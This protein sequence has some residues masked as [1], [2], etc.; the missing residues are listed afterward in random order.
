MFSFSF[1]FVLSPTP[2]HDGEADPV[3]DGVE[4]FT[5]AEVLS[6]LLAQLGRG[7]IETGIDLC[8]PSS[9]IGVTDRTMFGEVI[10]GSS[11][12]ERGRAKGVLRFSGD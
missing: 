12:I 10:P 11:D 4:D 2:R 3:V 7:R 6:V 8:L 1:F 9:V 5:V